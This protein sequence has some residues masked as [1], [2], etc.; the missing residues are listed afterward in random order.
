LE[1]LKYENGLEK[2]QIDQ[3]M[4][5][6]KEKDV[7]NQELEYEITEAND[8]ILILNRK[9]KETE[10]KNVELEKDIKNYKPK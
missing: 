2:S 3:L 9:I 8:E 1:N 5:K 10:E 4:I 7:I 6:L